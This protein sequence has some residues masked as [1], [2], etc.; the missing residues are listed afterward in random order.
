MPSSRSS[1]STGLPPSY[2]T[3]ASMDGMTRD[4]ASDGGVGAPDL[5]G[6]LA[7]PAAR[8]AVNPHARVRGH[9]ARGLDSGRSDRERAQDFQVLRGALQGFERGRDWTFGDVRAELD[10]KNVVPTTVGHRP[11]LE[12]AQIH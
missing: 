8:V 6:R 7:L 9:V 3:S 12:L 2:G 10:V 1:S 11:G 5:R 4:M